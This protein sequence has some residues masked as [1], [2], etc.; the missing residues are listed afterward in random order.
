M[1][2]APLRVL[3]VDDTPEIRTMLR[4]MLDRHGM[5][6]LEWTPGVDA[7]ELTRTER[8]DV[9]ILDWGLPVES[10]L[11]VCRRL[12]SDDEL[13][14]VPVLMFTGLSDTRD[15]HAAR[16]AG[17]DAFLTKGV[18]GEQVARK[19]RE[20]VSEHKSSPR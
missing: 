17:A 11:S 19:V 4:L 2:E 7:V 15:R 12:K 18:D 8:P 5:Q 3:V 9:V 10:G 16:H 14:E 13:K 20:V 1:T 6:V